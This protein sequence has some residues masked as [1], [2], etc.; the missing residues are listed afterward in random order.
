MEVCCRT[1]K[2]AINDTKW[3]VGEK[4]MKPWF[5]QPFGQDYYCLNSLSLS[6]LRRDWYWKW[7]LNYRIK[8]TR[9]LSFP[10]SCTRDSHLFLPTTLFLWFCRFQLFHLE[11][12]YISSIHGHLG[13]YSSSW[14]I[15]T[16]SNEVRSAWSSRNKL[17]ENVI[18]WPLILN[19]YFQ[20]ASSSET[21][22]KPPLLTVES[23]NATKV[24]SRKK[25]AFD[26]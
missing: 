13:G 19:C 11:T 21:R 7:G 25:S 4:K 3:S 2:R 14:I 18:A 20:T 23:L 9:H 1:K 24:L 17:H 26:H 10:F 16:K 15:K 12:L 6:H 8:S 5:N 22:T